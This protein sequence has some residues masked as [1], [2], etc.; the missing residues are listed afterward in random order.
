MRPVLRVECVREHLSR[1]AVRQI[2]QPA[3]RAPR[4]AV[5]Q[6]G[7]IRFRAQAF[8]Q[9]EAVQRR[10]LR[11]MS[12]IQRVE[13][14]TD[15]EAASRVAGA[16][17][18]AEQSRVEGRRREARQRA[19]SEVEPKDPLSQRDH[20]TRCAREQRERAD[21]ARHRPGPLASRCR[22]EAIQRGSLY[23]DPIERLLR[24][25]PGRRFADRRTCVRE[26][27]RCPPIP[28]RAPSSRCDLCRRN[29]AK[30]AA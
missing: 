11:R 21:V 19:R 23:V 16:L 12:S 8:A 10:C 6:F 22:I 17:V 18:E 5:M 14:H 1:L 24:R 2:E 26:P 25:H 28:P 9:G 3:V 29:A 13:H 20:G 30:D 7:G 4:H 15:P 27:P